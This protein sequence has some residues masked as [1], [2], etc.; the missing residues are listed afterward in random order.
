MEKASSQVRVRFA[1]SPTGFLHI[2]SARTALYNWL[3]A[4]NRKGVF[5]LR[6]EDTDT[7]RSKK[8]FLEE[9]MDSLKWLGLDWDE[10]PYFQSQRLERYREYAERLLAQG[11]A[12]KEHDPGKGEA[13]KFK[14]PSKKIVFDDLIHGKIAF[15]AEDIKDQV[16]IKSDGIAAYNFACVIDDVEMGIT[17]VI[18]GDDHISN[19]PKQ[20]LLYEALGKPPPHFVHIPLILGEDRSRLSK[21]HGATAIAEYRKQG[22]LPEALVNYLSLLGWSPGANVEIISKDSIVKKFSLKQV[23]VTGA[24]FDIDKFKWINGNYIKAKKPEELYE[25]LAPLLRERGIAVDAYDRKKL[26][27]II[28]LFQSRIKVLS[29]FADQAQFFFKDDFAHNP[30]AVEKFLKRPGTQETMHRL[31][32]ALKTSPSFDAQGIEAIIRAL[33]EELKMKAGDI[34]QPARVLLTGKSVSPGFFEIV[35][36]IGKDRTIRLLEKGLPLCS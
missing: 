10:G 11:V 14:M 22:F 20:V 33:A 6:I 25:L 21:R 24:V 9:I 16:L 31:C 18:R 4:R 7:E 27:E 23:N 30:E 28:K 5:I 1:P 32:V 34:M 19:T 26:L 12:Y 15:D 8:E 3:F 13:I 17:H 29:E 2:G 35:T 36:L